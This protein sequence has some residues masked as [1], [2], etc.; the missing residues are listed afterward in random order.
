MRPIY[1][2]L[3]LLFAMI[4]QATLFVQKPFNWVQPSL[5]VVLT[6][7]IAYFRNQ[8]LAMVLGLMVGLVQD[9]VYGTLI[10][11]HTFSLA[12]VGYFSGALFRVFLNRSLIM[13]LFM[14]LGM[15]V[16]YEF[17]NYG[18]ATIFGRLR[19]DLLVVLTHAVRLMIFNGIYGL[20]LYPF[21]ERW[22]PANEDWRLGEEQR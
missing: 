8:R 22:L 11:M 13:L 6:V 21:A 2:F 19:I 18:I 5:T 4:L 16:G 3:V 14:V 1:V 12:L 9:V 20:L 10:G 17:L 7:F 15:T